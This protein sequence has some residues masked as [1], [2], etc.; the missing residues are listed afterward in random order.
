VQFASGKD[1]GTEMSLLFSEDSVRLN[2]HA[3]L[4]VDGS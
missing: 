1:G 2:I 3:Y 4:V